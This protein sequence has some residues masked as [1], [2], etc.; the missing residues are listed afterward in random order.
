MCH[1]LRGAVT[2][3]NCVQTGRS[4]IQMMSMSRV[5]VRPVAALAGRGRWMSA[6]GGPQ[7]KAMIMLKRKEGI[8]RADFESEMC[9]GCGPWD[10]GRMACGVLHSID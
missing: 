5:G 7:F 9:G 1:A 4:R 2:V 6:A 3:F 10:A 8:K